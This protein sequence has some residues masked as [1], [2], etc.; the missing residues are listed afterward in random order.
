MNDTYSNTKLHPQKAVVIYSNKA[1]SEFY[2]ES[3]EIK[4]RNGKYE[5]MAPVALA[6]NVL[7]QIAKSYMKTNSVDMHFGGIIAPH[8]LHG[9]NKPGQ[10]VVIWYRPAMKKQLNFSASLRIKGESLVN[11]PATLY[12][13]INNKLYL[14]A[15]MTDERPDLKTKIYNAPFFNIY[16]DGNVC[17]GTAPVGK[18]KAATFDGEAQRFERA[19]YMAEQNGGNS[20]NNCKTPLAKLWGQLI[21]TK[22][23]FP[24]KKE[25]IQH[26]QYKTLGGLVTKLITNNSNDDD[27]DEQWDEDYEG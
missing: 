10:T 3:R 7:Q 9:S 4:N 1:G 13:V 6:D 8:L 22:A 15:L 5:M 27:Y 26:K 24:S 12:V 18:Q 2:L 14:F 25:L 20:E 17:L 19:F 11:I 21:K 16:D 23:P